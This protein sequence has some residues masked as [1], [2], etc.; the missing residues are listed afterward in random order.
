V[1]RG[2]AVI[3]LLMHLASSAAAD[4]TALQYL[5][6]MNHALKSLNYHGTVVYSSGSTVDSMQVFHKVSPSGEQERLIHL[7][8]EPREVLRTNDVVTCYMPEVRSVMVGKRSLGT[9]F[10]A[11][12]NVNHPLFSPNYD[13]V[14]E[15][16]DRVA[17]K[18]TLVLRILAKD[19]Y[20]YGYRLWLDKD[21]FLLLKSALLD[22]AGNVLE[23]AMFAKLEVVSN[24]PDAMLKSSFHGESFTWHRSNNSQEASATHNT[25]QLL[26]LPSGFVLSEADHRDMPNS[27]NGADHLVV[28]DGLAS[29]S[30]YIETFGVGSQSVVGAKQFGALNVYGRILDDHKVTVVGEVPAMTAK[31]IAEALNYVAANNR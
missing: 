4:S 31:M 21:N 20:R 18:S 30:V 14:V 5:Q 12:F 11:R 19:H 9:A 1:I 10:S 2:I 28:S 27:E 26:N 3:G 25:W 16:S 24:I 29:V 8:G 23:Q 15:G 6:R 17:G 7:S 22:P 13:L